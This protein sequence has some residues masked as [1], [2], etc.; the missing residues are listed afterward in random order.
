MTET[1][2]ILEI[3]VAVAHA[4]NVPLEALLA[5]SP[6]R[7]HSRPRFAA[8]Y[9]TRK[10]TGKSPTQI[11]R[12]F[13]GRN[14]TTVLNGCNRADAMRKTDAA[15]N[16]KLAVARWRLLHPIEF[17]SRNAPP[18]QFIRGTQAS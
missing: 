14:H 12:S 4:W 8:M 7:R 18:L 2:T 15:F 11:G 10:L 6:A 17:K 5:P 16:Q 9:L 3:Q 1:P 13:G